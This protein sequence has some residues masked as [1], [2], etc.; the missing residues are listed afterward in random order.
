MQVFGDFLTSAKAEAVVR[1]AF[2]IGLFF[3]RELKCYMLYERPNDLT[4]K[5]SPWFSGTILS[6]DRVDYKVETVLISGTLVLIR[7][8][9]FRGTDSDAV[10][11]SLNAFSVVS[12]ILA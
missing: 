4:S 2:P 6:P 1:P 10:P 11:L 9:D 12:F 8:S 7:N 3:V 5:M